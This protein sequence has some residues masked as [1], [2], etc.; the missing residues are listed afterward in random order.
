M[1]VSDS[2]DQLNGVLAEVGN[3]MAQMEQ[4]IAKQESYSQSIL[5][6]IQSIDD[7]SQASKTAVETV[8]IACSDMQEKFTELEQRLSRLKTKR[9]G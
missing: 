5:N 7:S 3:N 2:F 8:Q 6:N 4:A 9:T 1:D